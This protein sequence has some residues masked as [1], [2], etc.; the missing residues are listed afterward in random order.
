M[1]Q[2]S[3]TRNALFDGPLVRGRN[4]HQPLLNPRPEDGEFGY[5]FPQFLPGSKTVLFEINH[6]PGN[7]A[8]SSFAV[9]ARADRRKKVFLEHA[10]MYP[11]YLPSGHLTWVSKGT[12]FASPFDRNA[13]EIRGSAQPVLEE[14]LE[15]SGFWICSSELFRE[16]ND[17]LPAGKDGGHGHD[18]KAGRLRQE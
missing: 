18:S 13:L 14:I 15:Q 12:L 8:A 11:R 17:A 4:H 3:T 1:A 7:S 6:I 16:R 5:R 9:V 2:R 10:G